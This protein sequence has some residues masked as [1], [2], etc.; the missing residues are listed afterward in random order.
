MNQRSAYIVWVVFFFILVIVIV[1][2]SSL[3]YI[4]G[5]SNITTAPEP[6]LTLNQYTV[7]VIVASV[8][9]LFI[10]VVVFWSQ[11]NNLF[12]KGGSGVVNLQQA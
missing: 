12:C 4:Q 2:L 9:L 3:A 10:G 11:G 1:A 5:G 6:L 8:L 7:G